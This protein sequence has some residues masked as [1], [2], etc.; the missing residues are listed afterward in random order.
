MVRKRVLNRFS[1]AGLK[2]RLLESKARKAARLQAAK[3]QQE[4]QEDEC[5]PDGD[6]SGPDWS[7]DG[8]GPDANDPRGGAGNAP[9]A[10]AAV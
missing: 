10:V 7:P 8:P 3:E 6:G 9:A 1:T 4:E 5:R 2:A